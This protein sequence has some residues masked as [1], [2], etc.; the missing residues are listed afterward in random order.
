MGHWVSLPILA[1]AAILQSTFIPQ[2]RIFGGQP[3]FVVL[4]VVCWTVLSRL[5]E[6]ITWAFVGGI[7]SDLLSAAPVGTSIV[8]LIFVVFLVERLKGQIVSINLFVLFGLTLIAVLI[9]MFTQMIIIALAGF[10]IRP[11]EQFFYVIVPSLAYNLAFI[12]P[13]YWFIRRIKRAFTPGRRT[14]RRLVIDP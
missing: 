7:L 10:T 6:G 3:D 2:I 4:F 5:E 13:A 8:G 14:A 1:F 11:L 9:Q 12:A